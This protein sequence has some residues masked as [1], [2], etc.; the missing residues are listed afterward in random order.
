MFAVVNELLQT[1]REL[2]ELKEQLR[3]VSQLIDLFNKRTFFD[4]FTFSYN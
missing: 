4:S 1:R 3:S 2:N